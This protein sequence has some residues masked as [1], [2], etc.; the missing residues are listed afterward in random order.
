MIHRGVD[1]NNATGR[2]ITSNL[3]QKNVKLVRQ[4]LESVFKSSSTTPSSEIQW[5]QFSSY[6][7]IQFY[8]A[9]YAGVGHIRQEDGLQVLY[10]FSH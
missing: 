9:Y 3:I 1:P 2:G 10:F 5:R 7:P 6:R 8:L 4:T